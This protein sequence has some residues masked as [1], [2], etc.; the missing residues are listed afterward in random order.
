MTKSRPGQE[1]TP[2]WLPWTSLVTATRVRSPKTERSG[3]PSTG[4]AAELNLTSNLLYVLTVA[5]RFDQVEQR[6]GEL[7]E[8]GGAAAGIDVRPLHFRLS[9]VA[10]LRGDTDRARAH[11]DH[12]LDL[13][14]GDDVQNVAMAASLEAALALAEGDYSRA[15]GAASKAIDIGVMD[16]QIPSHESVRAGFPDAVDAALAV[17]DLDAA[18]GL[19]ALF[20]ERPPG[21]VLPFLRMH[22]RRARALAA[23]ARADDDTVGDV[24][25]AVETAFAELGYRYWQARTQLDLAEWF[26]GVGRLDEATAQAE[27]AAVTFEELRVTPMAARARRVRVPAR[28]G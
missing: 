26:A 2:G 21:D 6:A 22:A 10:A 18:D 28:P 8:L 24:L 19:V 13:A 14:D 3:P 17:G 15:L 5:G 25:A 7:L 23:A 16:L 1:K 12:C 11:A 4:S 20:A 27:G 9:A